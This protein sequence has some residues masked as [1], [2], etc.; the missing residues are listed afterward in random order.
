MV[1]IEG[2][3]KKGRMNFRAPEIKVSEK[4]PHDVG[5]VVKSVDSPG[6]GLEQKTLS[7]NPGRAPSLLNGSERGPNLEYDWMAFSSSMAGWY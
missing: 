3:F 5:R 4:K 7:S 1:Y 2:L 6:D